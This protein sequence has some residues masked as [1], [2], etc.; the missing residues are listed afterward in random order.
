MLNLEKNIVIMAGVY[1]GQFGCEIKINDRGRASTDGKVIHIPK[2]KPDLISLTW[3]YCAHEA[4]HVRDTNNDLVI[5]TKK[6]DHF[7]GW[8]LNVIE[9]TRIEKVQIGYFP[10]IKKYFNELS[11]QVLR[12]EPSE[13]DSLATK[14]NDYVFYYI[15]GFLT[16]YPIWD[17]NTSALKEELIKEYGFMFILDVDE[18]LDRTLE[19]TSTEEALELASQ[20]KKL[21]LDKSDEESEEPQQQQESGEPENSGGEQDQTEE[22]QGGQDNSPSEDDG[23]QNSNQGDDEANGGSDN[24]QDEQS[25]DHAEGQGSG[26]EADDGDLSDDAKN[27]LKELISR[28][29]DE[30]G[31]GDLGEILEETLNDP[32]N[33]EPL[34][35]EEKY[36]LTPSKEQSVGI[37]PSQLDS[38]VT[39][40][41]AATSNLRNGLIR[42]IEEKTRSQRVVSK[43]GRKLAKGKAH[44]LVSGNHRIFKRKF[45][46]RDEV[47]CDVA[48]LADCSGS[49][50]RDIESV[51]VATHALLDCLGKIDGASTCAYGFGG[52]GILEIQRPNQNYDRK[53]QAKVFSL[54]PMGGTPAPQAYWTAI[55]ALCAMGACNKVA[56]MV[57]DGAPQDP[58]ATASIVNAMRKQG[59]KVIA[60]GVGVDSSSSQTLDT[61]YGIKKW[62]HV[63]QFQDLPGELIR[64]AEQVI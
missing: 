18:L 39:I 24:A 27:A 3:G 2:P 11:Y 23:D 34:T 32:N 57:T 41:S 58:S 6:R 20:V 10:A 49:M 59:I 44:R 38:N 53:V 26:R 47:S 1:A 61:V 17:E 13:N 9:D 56:L 4:G 51:K 19:L 35:S 8:L 48:V 25:D 22:S 15:R 28:K 36:G 60:I 16:R 7:L 55:R 33:K 14:L 43:K 54:K 45:T 21:I 31:K 42:L 5:E 62:I 30:L 52:Q 64:V 63:K 50:G 12:Y 40:A 37:S 46:E 29:A